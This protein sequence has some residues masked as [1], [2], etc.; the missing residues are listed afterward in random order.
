MAES[1]KRGNCESLLCELCAK[2]VFH[3]YVNCAEIVN[4]FYVNCAEIVNHFYVNCVL[5]LQNIKQQE[6]LS[7]TGMLAC[8]NRQHTIL[9]A[10]S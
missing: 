3:F 5:K 2:I 9:C 4:N 1:F 7:D 6:M 8:T 10:A